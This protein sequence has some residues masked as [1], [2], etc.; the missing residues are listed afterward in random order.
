MFNTGT[1]HRAPPAIKGKPL[2]YANWIPTVQAL[3]YSSYS[4]NLKGG[5]VG[6]LIG[7]HYIAHQR[8]Y[9]ELSLD[10]TI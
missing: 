5:Y 4:L 3:G 9:Q 10:K 1:R 8:G 2:L 7:D 6:D